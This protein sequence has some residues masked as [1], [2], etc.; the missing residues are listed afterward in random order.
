MTKK[1]KNQ[2]IWGNDA[3]CVRTSKIEQNILKT[4]DGQMKTFRKYQISI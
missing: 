3:F 2:W 1:L 4:K